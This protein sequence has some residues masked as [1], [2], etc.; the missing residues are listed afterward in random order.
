MQYAVNTP[1]LYITK[2]VTFYIVILYLL[3]FNRCHIVINYGKCSEVYKMV[4][5]VA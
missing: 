1:Q 5:Q 3:N 4:T 2:T